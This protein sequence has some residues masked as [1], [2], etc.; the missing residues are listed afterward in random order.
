LPG[1]IKEVRKVVWAGLLALAVIC[2]RA[3]AVIGG[4]PTAVRIPLM[5][6]E[7]ELSAEERRELNGLLP[8]AYR[9]LGLAPEPVPAAAVIVTAIEVAC[10]ASSGAA[11]SAGNGAS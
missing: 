8:Q 11:S 6:D 2:G 1:V 9:L 4:Y 7:R 10:S 3:A 5:P